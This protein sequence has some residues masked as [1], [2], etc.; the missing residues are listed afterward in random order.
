[1]DPFSA[2][3]VTRLNSSL[4]TTRVE[5]KILSC[6]QHWR[7]IKLPQHVLLSE[8]PHELGESRGLI[9]RTPSDAELSTTT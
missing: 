2:R 5:K 6:A 9:F 7:I 3:T 4:M 8:A 1:M